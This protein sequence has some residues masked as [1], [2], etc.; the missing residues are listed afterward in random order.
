LDRK[1]SSNSAVAGTRRL[2]PFNAIVEA[3][4]PRANPAF[5]WHTKSERQRATNARLIDNTFSGRL[6]WHARNA[7]LKLKINNRHWAGHG[8]PF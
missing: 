8:N 3:A 7:L 6:Q 4:K 2:P 5:A 1:Y